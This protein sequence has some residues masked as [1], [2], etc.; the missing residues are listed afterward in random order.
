MAFSVQR[1][2]HRYRASMA[3]K[4]TCTWK[5]PIWGQMRMGSQE[6]REKL[7]KVRFIKNSLFQPGNYWFTSQHSPFRCQ[8]GRAR[9]WH[10][11]FAWSC[12][13][14]SRRLFSRSSWRPVAQTCS[15]AWSVPK[16][17]TIH[18]L[19]RCKPERSCN[20]HSTPPSTAARSSKSPIET[21][22]CESKPSTQSWNGDS[23]EEPAMCRRQLDRPQTHKWALGWVWILCRSWKTNQLH[24]FQQ[25][26]IKVRFNAGI[27][28]QEHRRGVLAPRKWLNWANIKNVTIGQN[29]LQTWRC[30]AVN[31]LS[32]FCCLSRITKS[33]CLSY[34]SV[35]TVFPQKE[36]LRNAR[37]RARAS[38]SVF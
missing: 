9:P 31:W 30:N 16:P 15:T 35:A 37:P 21:V 19:N 18:I 23:K 36:L 11:I 33:T 3:I 22:K 13:A 25:T 24:S 2:S 28:M 20:R 14:G 4:Q 10:R 26:C 7:I 34:T 29:K 27:V 8:S 32:S 12:F 38:W 5:Q 1:S 6:E 17:K